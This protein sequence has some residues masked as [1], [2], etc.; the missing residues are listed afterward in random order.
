MKDFKN[1]ITGSNEAVEFFS[2][3]IQPLLESTTDLV[4]VAKQLK[5]LRE[6]EEWLK[7][8]QNLSN[9]L[10]PTL[11]EMQEICSNIDRCKKKFNVE[12]YSTKKISQYTF[13]FMIERRIGS[14]FRALFADPYFFKKFVSL[15]RGWADWE[16]EL[17]PNKSNPEKR[18]LG[19]VVRGA[20]TTWREIEPGLIIRIGG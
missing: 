20:D 9:I 11:E 12:C 19:F 13:A 6:R 4:E 17:F 10:I 8:G 18:D 15:C 16:T 5:R 7:F 2:K 1:L 14:E 3:N